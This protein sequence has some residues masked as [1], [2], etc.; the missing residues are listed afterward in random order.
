MRIIIKYFLYTDGDYR[1]DNAEAFGCT[2]REVVDEYDDYFDY[3]GSAEFHNE[4]DLDCKASAKDFLWKFLCDG[5]R[6]SYMHAWLLKDFYNIIEELVNQIDLFD[7]GSARGRRSL[8][9]NH[10]ATRIEIE[11]TNN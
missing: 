10:S 7:H 11:M 8:N 3:V 5:I 9:G 2:G 4:S 1:L 6:V